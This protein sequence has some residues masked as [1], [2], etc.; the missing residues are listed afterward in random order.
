MFNTIGAT[1]DLNNFSQT[2]PSLQG[3]GVNGGNVTLGSAIL[4]LGSGAST[5]YAG[6][7][8]GSGGIVKVGSS[9]FTL[10]GVNTYSG[11]TTINNGTLALSNSGA[12]SQS[13]V[14][15]NSGIFDISGITGGGTQIAD[16]SGSRVALI[17]LGNKTLTFGTANSTTFAG[18]I[19]NGG[20]AGGSPGS[21][22]KEGTGTFN[23][24]GINTYGG[25]TTINAGNFAVNGDLISSLVTVTAGATLSG[26]SVIVGDV[27]NQGTVSPGNSIGTLTIIGN[28]TQ[29]A[30][31]TLEI[32][33]SPTA[34][35]LLSILGTATI[36]PG[37]T[38]HL[39]PFSGTYPVP[40]TYTILTSAGRTGTFSQ[41]VNDSPAVQFQVRYD[42]F[43]VYLDLISAIS[44]TST[45]GGNIGKIASYLSALTPSTGTD[46]FYVLDVL[47]SLQDAAAIN[48]AL[49]QLQPAP[50]KNMIL[51][52][53]ENV[54]SVSRTISDHLNTMINTRCQRQVDR[55]NQYEVWSS[56]FGDYARMDD[57]MS[58]HCSADNFVGY[59]SKGG[60]AL[61]GFDYSFTNQYVV[62]TGIGYSYSGVRVNDARVK[63]H[64]NSGYGIL[65]AMVQD[66]R[67]FV[68]A[69]F[70]VG[71]SHF[72]ASRKIQFSTID[73][74]AYTCH[75]GWNIDGHLD[76]G[77]IIDHWKFMEIRPFISLD[78][79]IIHENGHQE[80]G[81]NSLDL[82]IDG[83]NSS[84]FR[85]EGGINFSKCFRLN[86]GKWIPELRASFVREAY[87]S[88][89]GTYQSNLVDQPLSFTVKN[90][91]PNRTL[92]SPG[93]K[94]TGVF[95]DDK[96]WVEIDY[97]GE[98]GTTYANQVFKA[99]FSWVL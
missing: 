8:S 75:G 38:L 40:K 55:E 87:R 28:Y 76:A 91:V 33:V 83:A 7:I 25:P 6:S 3:G 54:F 11:T 99:E 44:S 67:F 93:A 27:F 23:I 9:V 49:A 19:Q 81:A 69:S 74:R 62:G 89:A 24:T 70:I 4:T 36:D 30:G 96:M 48:Q 46:L 50:Y 51:A 71:Y 42:D 61:I 94:V 52:Q 43:N 34:A 95:Y 98:Y 63:G 92:F 65:Y 14:V 56:V 57:R 17:K 78:G 97:F 66:N 12:I 5:T 88:S 77:L 39:E 84:L 82:I 18:N 58:H 59:R 60:G 29:T 73:R 85:G 35:D 64:I 68:D 41:V 26:V 79:L 16:L 45:C 90:R 20:I 22:V 2:I 15:I 10:T 13:S 53:E 21:L 31:S 86:Y 80:E 72:D 37:A 47:S 1:L 32:E